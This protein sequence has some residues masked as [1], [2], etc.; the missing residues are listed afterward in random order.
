VAAAGV[1]I[2]RAEIRTTRGEVLARGDLGALSRRTGAPA[3]CLH[4]AD[5]QAVLLDSLGSDVVHCGFTCT[6]FAQD[7]AGITAHYANGHEER[8]DLLIGADGLHS[9]VRAQLLGREPPRYA[10]YTAWRGVAPIDPVGV[11]PQCGF[12][13]WGRGARFGLFRV[14]GGRTYWFG[15]ANAP[16]GARDHP[17]GRKHDVLTRFGD[18]HAPIVSLIEATDETEILRHD[19]YDRAPARRWGEGRVTVLGDAAHPMTP[20]LAQGAGMAIEDGAAL[21]RWLD[22]SSEVSAALRGYEQERQAR[23][24]PLVLQSRRMGWLAQLE[25]PVACLVRDHVVKLTPA[26]LMERQLDSIVSGGR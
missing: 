12:E 4:R 14:S 15:V 2:E 23:T 3:I 20:N 11:E 1:P 22:R 16:E 26:S 19:I 18:W 6:D 9:A 24:A 21:A 5:L 8:G 7:G 13:S 10:G 17:L 25:H